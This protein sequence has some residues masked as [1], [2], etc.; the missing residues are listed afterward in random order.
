MW[1][2]IRAN[3]GLGMEEQ[4]LFRAA[5]V[6]MCALK[7]RET[8]WEAALL[9]IEGI[10]ANIHMFSGDWTLEEAKKSAVEELRRMGWR[11]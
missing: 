1:T 7:R 9:V 5:G 11:W 8:A 4:W 3:G 6:P 10:S 2:H